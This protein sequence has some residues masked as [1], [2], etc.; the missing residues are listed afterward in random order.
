M[1]KTLRIDGLDFKVDPSP[2]NI[3][4]NH[5]MICYTNSQIWLDEDMAEDKSYESLL[6]EALHAIDVNRAVGLKEKQVKALANGLFAF[7]RANPTYLAALLVL[8]KEKAT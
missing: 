1:L 8:F 4:D 5:A 3:N 7:L 2:S 6:H